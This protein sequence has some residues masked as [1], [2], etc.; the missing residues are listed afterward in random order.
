[1]NE[2]F[3]PQGNGRHPALGSSGDWRG[4]IRKII[5]ISAVALI[6]CTGLAVTPIVTTQSDVIGITMPLFGADQS[7]P[8]A[9]LHVGR[10]SM[11]AQREGFFRVGILPL[12]VLK[13][14]EIDFKAEPADA[15][16]LGYLATAFETLGKTSSAELHDVA[17]V[18][19][20]QPVLFASQGRLESDASV[21]LSGVV[22][23]G[24]EARSLDAAT[25]YTTGTKAGEVTYEANG[26]LQTE[27]L[28]VK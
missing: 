22:L 14:V 4:P 26:V 1:V 16:A 8:A 2:K 11:E 7:K 24:Q 19:C 6:G 18:V 27:N 13:K 5:F 20:G 3:D 12:L 28:F 23:H 15:G 10:A 25:L 21:R 9:L 17:I